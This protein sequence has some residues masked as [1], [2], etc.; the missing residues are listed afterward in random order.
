MAT[1]P[2]TSRRALVMSSFLGAMGVLHLVRPDRFDEFIPPELPG[3]PR[4]WTYAS[5]VA[6]IAVAGALAVPSTRRVGALAAVGLFVGVLPGNLEMARRWR[7][8]PVWPYQVLAWGRIPLQI[9]M[10]RAAYAL[11]EAERT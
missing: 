11:A 9:P 4:T 8:K 2:R 7:H 5:G 3:S 6:E 10:I 1:E